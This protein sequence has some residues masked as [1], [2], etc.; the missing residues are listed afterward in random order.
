MK[1][2]GFSLQLTTGQDIDTIASRVKEMGGTLEP[3]P[4]DAWG[5]RV[6]RVRVPDAFVLVISSDR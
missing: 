2:V 6:F 1:G 3:E 4:E 5:A